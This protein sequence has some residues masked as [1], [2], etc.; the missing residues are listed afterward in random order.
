MHWK[1]LIVLGMFLSLWLGAQT[2]GPSQ[3]AFSPLGPAANCVA[4]SGGNVLCAASDGFYISVAGGVFEKLGGTAPPPPSPTKLTCTT[5]SLSSGS[6]GSLT[7]SGC[8]FQ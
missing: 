8:V 2:T 4:A 6:S 7:A 5:A 3:M 1:K